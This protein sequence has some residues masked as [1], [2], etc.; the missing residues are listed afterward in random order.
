MALEAGDGFISGLVATNPVNAT[1]EVA[2]GDDHL[3]LIKTALKGTFPNLNGAVNATPAQLNVL[4]T[5]GA[6]AGMLADIAA[7][8]DPGADRV[9]GWDESANA[10]IAFS[11]STGLTSSGTTLLIDTTVVPQ[12]GQSNTFT[13][14]ELRHSNNAP[15]QWLIDANAA[16]DTKKFRLSTTGAALIFALINDAE[17]VATTVWQYDRSGT[18]LTGVTLGQT[19]ATLTLNG[20]LTTGNTAATEVGFKG[21]PFNG[22]AG[23]YT[24]VL[25]DCGKTIYKASGGAGETITI[26][27]N[28]S[29][30]FPVGTQ[31][32]IVNNGGGD[33]TIAITSDTLSWVVGGA[34]GS[35]TLGDHGWCVLKKVASTEWFISGAN[36]T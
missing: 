36:L 27:A 26:P 31:I 32:D 4:V 35:R 7:I 23:D 29:V 33:L 13:G 14:A 3:R 5:D 28:A 22:Q 18:T 20:T 30:A 9:L 19:G 17:T 6:G 21:T 12:L 10:A 25:T 24:L 2:Q 8:A 1:D 34:T 15:A 16:V 11:L